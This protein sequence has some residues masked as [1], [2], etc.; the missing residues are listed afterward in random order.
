MKL[1]R[2]LRSLAFLALCAVAPLASG[3]SGD[4]GQS[5][6]DIT[7]VNHTNVERQSIGNCWIYAEA[8]WAESM[9]LSATGKAFDISQS[10]WTYW[11]WFDQITNG[12]VSGEIETGGGFDVARE[13]VLDRGLMAETSFVKEDSTSEMSQRQHDALATINTELKTGRLKDASSR[14][15]G[16]LVRT[17][18]DQAW[19][20]TGSVTSRLTKVFGADGQKTFRTGA[21]NK[22]ATSIIKPSS[23]KV[24][25]T[26]R[27]TDP[28]KPT[29]KITT[30]DVAVDEWS[31]ASYPGTGSDSQKRNFMIRMQKAAHDR[32]P[33]VITWDVDFNAMENNDPVLKGSFNL[34]TLKSAG[35]A[36]R[37]GG[38]MTVL[39]DYEA[40]TKMFGTLKAGETLDP[41]KPADKAKLDAA[42]DPSTTISF[43]RIK[44]SWGALRDDR[45]FAPGFPGYH[46]LYM[47]YLNGP[48]TW[49]PDV[50][51]T[52][53]AANCKG[54]AR[55][56][57]AM[58]FP[59]GY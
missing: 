53:T 50:E 24:Q 28:K 21:S 25:Y 14:A 26:E 33:I 27:L 35:G 11:H 41:T 8:S 13:I 46:D 2:A 54:S 17:V 1:H 9:N 43:I 23:F 49:C 52:K 38:H 37:Q 12:E 29:T 4:S 42:L 59:P 20:L 3:C 55:P 5:T 19:Q 18:L 51:T 30:L 45:A 48:I 40:V 22:G 39:E 57:Q 31:E 16:T 6:D 10:Y 58:A 15:N 36:G 32:Q 47:D 56:L 44:N 34:K 7:D